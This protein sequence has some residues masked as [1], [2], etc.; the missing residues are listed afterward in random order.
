VVA[1]ISSPGQA[2]LRD[3][4][5]V[6][7]VPVSAAGAGTARIIAQ[8]N[9]LALAPDQ[10]DIWV[11]QA[12]PPWGNGPAASP[13]WLIDEAGRRLSA[14]RGLPGR[15]LVAATVR[16]LL[17]QGSFGEVSLV[18]PASGRP[19]RTS[20][21]ADAVIAGADADHVAWR[22]ASCPAHCPLHVADVRGGP[23]IQIALPPHTAL[24]PAD[25]P[26]FDPAGQRF[27]LPLDTLNSQGTAT[28][29]YIYVADI[30]ARTLI[31]LPGGPV[32][33]AGLPA[34]LGAFPAGSSDVVCA[35]WA[36]DGSGLWIVATD[37]LF[38]QAGFWTGSGPL[39][40]LKP[41]AGLA[42]K[43]DVPGAGT[44]GR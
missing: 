32:P 6:V 16:G 30:K 13:A 31:R 3:T 44:A 39:H 42:Y 40:V 1:L 37:G 29:T 27:A 4:G 14:P 26:D 22:A 5:D 35:R 21:P 15:A 9:Y 10:R 43:F 23:G 33:V 2:G 11:E 24:D 38:A 8:A 17:V 41:Q 7:F 19:E 34:V 18:N 36:A 20:I 25:T 12:G 28:G